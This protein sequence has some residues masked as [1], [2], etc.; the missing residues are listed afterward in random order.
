MTKV[1]LGAVIALFVGLAAAYVGEIPSTALE[2][3][4]VFLPLKVLLVTCLP[5]ILAY[6]AGWED[7]LREGKVRR[8][9]L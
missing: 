3:Y 1:A 2:P 7:G 5:A 8:A 4:S 6:S 9:Q